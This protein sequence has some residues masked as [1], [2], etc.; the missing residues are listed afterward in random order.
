MTNND[1]RLR[2]YLKRA[3]ADLRQ[4]RRRLSEYKEPIAIVS[5]ACRYPG[6]VRRPEDLWRVVSEG[7]DAV[8]EFPEDRGWDVESLY[9]PDPEHEGT[10]YT[11]HGGFLQD[12]AEFDAEFFGISPREAL[13]TDPQQRLLLETAWEAF[14]RAGLEPGSLRGSRTGVFAGVMYNDYGSRLFG[15]SPEGFEGYLVSGSAGSV[16]SGRVSYTFG[17]EGPAVSVDT[18][19]SSSL[20]ALHLA[21]QA[22]RQGE[23]TL[24]LAGGVTVMSTPSTFV[25]FSRQKGLA[26]DGRCKPFAAAADGT[27][28]GEGVGL[29]VLERLSDAR[30]NGHPVLAVLRGT[31]VNQDGASSQLSAPNG[32]S[33]QRVIRQALAN[34]RLKPA[35]V[36]V[37]E[38]HGT[39]T[40]L[41][42]PIEAQALLATYGQDRPADRPL[43][44]GSVKSNIGH[45]QA[46]AGVA[47]V[48]KMVMAMRE[49]VLPKSLHVDA[50]SPHVDWE[51]GAVSLLDEARPWEENGHP[52]RAG[53]SSFGISG[54]NAHVIV[55]QAPEAAEADDEAEAGTDD[56]PATAA[57]T[58]VTER[59]EL[60]A[61]LALSARTEAALR[62]QAERLAAHLR[63]APDAPLADTAHALAT[64]RTHFTHRATVTA[65]THDEACAALDALAAGAPHPRLAQ[66]TAD[67]TG[68]RTAWMLTGQGSQ[69]PGMGRELHAAHPVFA[70]AFDEAVRHLDPHLDHPLRDIVFAEPGTKA[71][72]LLDTTRYAQPALFA[73]QTA[74][75]A[76]L[77]HH[78]AAPDVLIGHSIGE[79]TAAHL[80]GVL[81]LPDAARLVATRARL[82]QS[83]PTGG[84]MLAV[85]APRDEIAPHI[86][87][88]EHLVSIA[89][90]NGPAATV[91]S[92]DADAVRAIGRHFA[93][94]GTKTKELAVS[95]AFHSPHMEPVLAEFRAAAATVTYAEPTVPVIS[96]V[97]GE[98]AT[99]EQLTSPDYW[100]EHIRRPV[101]FHDGITALHADGVTRFLELGPDAVLTAAAL[102]TLRH[103]ADAAADAAVAV[104]TLRSGHPE[105]ESYTTA[106]GRLHT[107]GTPLALAGLHA[108]E[109][110]HTAAALPTYAFERRRYWLA[111]AAGTADLVTAGIDAAGH[112]LLGAAVTLAADDSVLLTG[113]LSL[114]THAWLADHAISGHPVLPGTALVDLALH[115]GEQVGCDTLDDLTLQAPLVLPEQGAVQLQL[116]LGAPDDAGRRALTCH[117]RPADAQGADEEWTLLATGT[118]IAAGPDS[119]LTGTDDAA[120]WP[121]AG[122]RAESLDGLYDR[123]A[124]LGY[125]YGPEFQNLTALWHA[126]GGDDLYAEVRLPD[127]AAESADRFGIHPALLDA[128]L[129][130]LA[131]ALGTSD[132]S[133]RLPFAWHGVRLGATG[134]TALRV[135]LTR[136][137]D[138]SM[139]LT[140]ADHE[141]RAVAEVETLAVRPVAPDD[142]VRSRNAADDALFG[143]AWTEVQEPAGSAADA[144]A[145]EPWSAVAGTVDG[146]APLPGVLFL[147][148]GGESDLS[149]DVPQDAYDVTGGALEQLKLLLADERFD[150]TR[151]VVVT[152][153]AVAA[154]PDEDVS[155]L[156][157]A[158]VWGLARTAQ[159]EYPGRVT[160]LD[161]GAGSAAGDV[162]DAV[163]RALTVGEP[164]LALR[165]GQFLAPRLVRADASAE[166]AALDPNGTVVVTGA[167]GTLGAR[168]A[169]HLVTAHGVRHLV[170]AS[171]RG[172]G[173]EGAAE[174]AAELTGLGAT[175]SVVACDAAD[176]AAVDAL[177]A[178]VDADHPVTAVVHA[179][180]VLDDA[181]LAGL[182]VEQVRRVMAPKAAAAWNLHRATQGL[183]L[184]AFVLFSSV[185]GTLGNAGQA[186]YAAAN[187]FLD[188]LAQHRHATGLP[189]TSVAWGLW[190]ESSGMTGH[191][192]DADLARVSRL[193]LA[194][195]TTDQGLALL[196]TALAAPSPVLVATRLDLTVLRG[197]AADGE[198]PALFR[199]LVRT[200]ARRAAAS[201]AR[202][203][204]SPWA[205]RLIAL[206][207]A[208]RY[209][210]ALELVR[211]AVATTLGHATPAA[212][213]A[214]RAFKDLGFDS[215]MAVELRNTLASLTGRR[216]S[217]TLVFD[218]P[219]PAALA[220][221]LVEETVGSAAPQAAVVVSAD[222]ADDP[223]AIVSMA[224][225]YPGGV[226]RPEDLWRVV[227]EGV[228]AVGEFPE[229]RGWDVESLYDPESGREGT[230]LTRHGGFLYDAA[231]FDAE[232]F[233]ISPR[234]ALA[235]DPQQ[236]LLLETAWEAFE[237]AGID[238]AGLRGS[239][240]GV[241]AGVMYNDYGSRL[242]GRAPE[243]FEG[244]LGNGSAG[245]V[246]SG[247]VSYTFGLEGPAVSVDTACSSSLVA[248][249]LAAQALRQGEC[250]LALAGGVTVMSTPL[251]FIEFSR[252]KALSADGR[253]KPFAAAAD[254]TGW[255]E[256]VGLLVLERLS[257]ARKNGH[258]VLAVLRGTATNQDGASNGL[259]APNGPS[260]QRVI[261]QALANARL[262]PGEVDVVE[263]H[264]T[265]TTLGDPIE[266]QALIATY[267][268]DRPADRPLWLGSVKSNIGHTQAAAGVAGVIKMVMAMREGVL[269][270][271]LH[272]DAP[273][274]HVDWEAGAVSL[275]DEARPWEE[276]GHPRRAGVSSFG[277]SGTNAHVIV[278]QA[279]EPST[280]ELTASEP[281]AS[282]S[283]ASE[284]V[285]AE[286]ADAAPV[287]PWILSA[288]DDVALREQA[289]R[290]REFLTDT[291]NEAANADPRDVAYALAT[292][293]AA[294]ESRAVVLGEDRDTLLAGL[295]ALAEGHESSA[296]VTGAA[297]ATGGRTV[298]V[299]P[300]QGSQWPAM[301]ASL[302]ATS[303]PFR[304]HI[305]ACADALAPYTD[306]SLRDLVTQAP[307]APDLDRVDVVQ[308]ALFA[309][310]TSL[311]RLWQAHGVQPDAVL[312]HSQGEIAAAYI[313]GALDLA[314]AARIAALRSKAIT[315]LEGTGGMVSVPLAADTTEALIGPWRGDVQIAAV[316][317]PGATV[318]SGAAAALDELLAHCAEREIR[319]RRIPVSYASHHPHV[320]ALHETLIEQLAGITPKSASIAFYSTVEAEPVD[321]AT[322]DVDY[323]YRNLRHTVRFEET[324]RRLVEDGHTRFI[325]TSPHPVLTVGLQD[326]IESTGTPATATGTLRRDQGTA[327]RFLTSLATVWTGGGPAD[328]P[329][330][331][332]GGR[333][334]Y[335]RLDLPTYAFQRRRY[336][337]EP[338]T[339]I[340]DASG[341]GQHT[342]DHP[343]L[344]AAVEVASGAG[345]LFT[346]RVSTTTHPWLTD[347]AVLDTVLLPG[348]AL[349]ELAL[350][351]GRH[352]GADE[353]DDLTLEAPLILAAGVSYDLQVAVDPADDA[354]VRAVH[355]HSREHREEPVAGEGW[356][357]HATGVLAPGAAGQGAGFDLAAWP[358]PNAQPY[359]LGDVY[360]RLAGH[361]YVY[362]PV[363][364]GLK[365]AWRDGDD[366]YVEVRL[367]EDVRGEG[368]RFGV[369]PALLD[370]ALHA[371]AL[372]GAPAEG[373][374]A[375]WQ[376]RLPFSWSG[377]R[378]YAAGASLLR[379]RLT[380]TGD[381]TIALRAADATGAPVAAVDTLAVRPAD[382]AELIASSARTA[383]DDDLLHTE[384]VTAPLTP[385]ADTDTGAFALLGGHSAG[386]L[387]SGDMDITVHE[388]LL[389]LQDAI[390][391]GGPAP[392][393]LL[394]TAVPAAN[395]TDTDIDGEEGPAQT[396]Q[397][398]VPRFLGLLQSWLADERLAGTTLVVATRNAVSTG[399]GDH[400]RHLA[401]ASLWGL[402]RSAQSEN[403]DRFLLIDLDGEPLDADSLHAALDSGEA[404]LAVRKGEILVPRLGRAATGQLLAAPADDPHWRL[405][406]KGTGSPDGLWLAPAPDAARP[407]G[408]G[409]VRVE[410]R[411]AGINFRDILI[412]LGMVA[413]D[414]R[415]P[416]GEGSG[417]VLE[418]GPGV[419]GIAPGDRVMGLL[420]EGVGPVTVA[421]QRVLTQ[422]PRGWT[423]A[424]AA[425]IPVVY[426]TAYYGLKD[427]AQV[428]RGESLL[429]HAATGGVGLATLQLAEHWGLT[430]YGTASPG[431]WRVLRAEGLPDDRIAS[432]RD[433]DFEDRFR[434]ASD[435]RGV[436]IVLN[437]L[438]QEYVDASLRL[439]APGGRFIEMGKTDIRDAAEVE[440]AYPGIRYQAFDVL[441]A[442]PDRVKEMLE[443]LRELFDSGALGPLPSTAW[444]IR[445]APEAFR[446]LS[447]ARQIGKVVLTLPAPQDP[448]GT[449]VVTG[450]SGTL[451]ARVARHLAAEHGAR[452]LVL[453][454]RRGPAAEGADE[455][456]RE[457]TTLGAQVSVVA[458]DVADEASVQALFAGIDPAHP[459]TSVVHTAGVLDDA[460]LAGLTQ[461]QVLRVMA[462]KVA[463][464]WHLHR[465]TQ[466]LDLS[467]FVLFSSMA[468]TLGNPGQANYAAANTFLDALA[469][470]RHAS[471]L[472]ATSLAWGLWAESSG[473]TGHLDDAD[474]A[475]MS[476]LGLAPITTEQGLDLYDR[477]LAA[478]EPVLLPVPLDLPALRGH[479]REGTLPPLLSG[480]VRTPVRRAA[481]AAG[482]ADTAAP[483]SLAADLAA[484]P[485]AD[486]PQRLLELVRRQV[487]AVLGLTGPEAVSTGKAFKQIGFDSLTAVELRNRL[488][489]ATGLR[490]AATVVFDFPTPTALAERLLAELLP[491]GG[492]DDAPADVKAVIAGLER[493]TAAGADAPDPETRDLLAAR[494]REALLTLEALGAPGAPG[495]PVGAAI[496]QATDDEIFDFI[497]SEL[498]LS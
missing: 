446:F 205:E 59:G 85:A 217:A 359:P 210:A 300:G 203:G 170:L 290:L 271:S 354:G 308:P 202:G 489:S 152:R 9:D 101:L 38:A 165:D 398:I 107:G 199:G 494:M 58:A 388:S 275:L 185:A 256:G 29:L 43:W 162:A 349:L 1:E 257:D 213:E 332:P 286:T 461:E 330:A 270:K 117:A 34:A 386:L 274:P 113:R 84:I 490:L 425:G 52:R 318:V 97:T 128:A 466:G 3:T 92:G 365:S 325:E 389:A 42:D 288:A 457:L 311:A 483:A 89:A 377:A 88:Q 277:V 406:S 136:T 429:L 478:A 40:T 131:A 450:A 112:P 174:L 304:D 363:F 94:Q 138:D 261:R 380:R 296:A 153:G 194:P 149:G 148:V 187:T 268:Q 233:G 297:T 463:A 50:P 282:E 197:K 121:P 374:D 68:G 310:M 348:T 312:G 465:A 321:T 28:W 191:L 102:E 171:R 278:E 322:L 409:E 498:G 255:G 436:D 219:S 372:D 83:A 61:L 341:L 475:R 8:G 16:A 458:C 361:G 176:A 452:H 340:S 482:G 323:W 172:P 206:P 166:P 345:L 175:V 123:L 419:T 371:L 100:T 137:G 292:H 139:A 78:G 424:Q 234:E 140:L 260:Q 404:Q 209:N 418:T 383:G 441:D 22:L 402:L 48:I 116:V 129:H 182:T 454:S 357:R 71:A 407:L 223:I 346:G 231:E 326:I 320:E 13:A 75:H 334:P 230:S 254:G 399:P 447:Q 428:R 276:N 189:A 155:D 245:S 196:D 244:Y 360:E 214:D 39:G 103:D 235:T 17:L 135:R 394:V 470:Y 306:W 328:W 252:Q 298:F 125:D 376:V 66:G 248:L 313:A 62:G 364:Q 293:R 476:R 168:V 160:L 239:R 33:Q 47:G 19:C 439:L 126:D 264:G 110:P 178:G 335:R 183:D 74:L 37:V 159:S 163:R 301:A 281:T 449:V 240:T 57:T 456:A 154:R 21:A 150:D 218:H 453:A 337:L 443:E 295:G 63:A 115:A 76:L 393:A 468:G 98:L 294:L 226:R 179:A 65:R 366:L 423:F 26:A 488:N 72:A 336:W 362:G 144:G 430:V 464:A 287:V 347:H 55:E 122:A 237:R 390:E 108:A 104:A 331:L 368:E 184:A 211:S 434:D 77:T 462:P 367:S 272:V 161:L 352:V 408:E 51:A 358:P 246:A 18:A 411:A 433:L 291:E 316:N 416:G 167:S 333:A 56:E 35:E 314:D 253:C 267:G 422:M 10:S 141:G 479:A 309:V 2:D 442:G 417:I 415:P 146:G 279:P 221:H 186:N 157:A 69:R 164:Q 238:A 207:E 491:D 119:W 79:L 397:T 455:L 44:L 266:A 80:A 492:Q 460:V 435:G 497:D 60:P 355:I 212:I 228:D 134:A 14:E 477:A 124:S 241:F 426:L 317:G 413:N 324:A 378:L 190:A 7:V 432:S 151:L 220:R 158:P 481:A 32:P 427:L 445:R 438:A 469:Q 49:G 250:S 181:V 385:A 471:G 111:P 375:A 249:H 299:F 145:P 229:D 473:M 289:D 64:A 405:A 31:A 474:L 127:D 36:D 208:E 193:G 24:A 99:T 114:A 96:D 130:P 90:V 448:E 440:S 23:C 236:R 353:V 243:G 225:R 319:A 414:A 224:C 109:E 53:V 222:T 472:P 431:K 467:S 387:A 382:L 118:L 192:D 147:T 395:G 280:P 232:F 379:V 265:G 284:T 410:V 173:A 11:R 54:T 401:G 373:S 496:D 485:A 342:A 391:S 70:R 216:L 351:A 20:V 93:D 403:P 251:T 12:A 45:T 195:I 142:L 263:A 305:D 495:E 25:E 156:A 81:E 421:D 344:S 86:E 4:A 133:V 392:R 369:H 95:H 5:M 269:P 437:S 285:G 105:P 198:L 307:G 6:G 493:L 188:A 30:K 87:G 396:A 27:G 204:G 169:R 487:A 350:H 73:L 339:T 303:A 381:D 200:R 120:A 459:V 400:V 201:P 356:T 15:R 480:L 420:P 177:F 106:L 343:L 412:A 370:A 91:V 41:G 227:A 215:L 262:E 180:G 338:E 486:R 258:P 273:S 242:S 67:T 302:Y 384:W 46:A 132:A 143:V 315:V 247:R 259:T 327:H 82:M 283:T 444:D 329:D 484:L 451:G